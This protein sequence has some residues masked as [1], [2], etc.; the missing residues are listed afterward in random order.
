[1]LEFSLVGWWMF[2]VC[3]GKFNYR[4]IS[5]IYFLPVSSAVLFQID[6]DCY[7]CE[8]IRIC[9]Q[10]NEICSFYSCFYIL[11]LF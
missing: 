3:V 6:V 9:V 1:V 2:V 11:E 5:R 4:L 10:A 7:M 8:F